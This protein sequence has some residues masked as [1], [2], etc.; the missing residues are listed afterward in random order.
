MM[1]KLQQSEN[2]AF[3]RKLEEIQE[4]ADARVD[5]VKK[6]LEA[7]RQDKHRAEKAEE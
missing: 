5:E 1:K 6:I 3:E 7:T 4:E 2:E